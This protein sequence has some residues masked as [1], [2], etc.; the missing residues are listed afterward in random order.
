M[1]EVLFLLFLMHKCLKIILY[2]QYVIL[3]TLGYYILFFN[4]KHAHK[5]P[6]FKCSF[7]VST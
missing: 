5:L 7:N 2:T 3:L 1:I 6:Y 4:K